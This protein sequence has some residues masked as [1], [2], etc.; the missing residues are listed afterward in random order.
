MDSASTKSADACALG[1]EDGSFAADNTGS[2]LA[3]SAGG[4]FSKSKSGDL[5]GEGEGC[6]ADEV[7]HGDKTWVLDIRLG[8]TMDSDDF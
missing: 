2:G 3:G 6:G 7:N 1:P 4:E 8:D 5:E